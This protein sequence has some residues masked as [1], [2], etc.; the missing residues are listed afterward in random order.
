MALNS[1]DYLF[2]YLAGRSPLHRMNA[3]VKLAL[4]FAAS[5]AACF[6]PLS[7]AAACALPAG[8]CARACGLPFRVQLRDLRPLLFYGEFLY[9]SAVLSK[10]LALPEPFAQASAAAL[11][12]TKATL[13]ALARL[14]LLLQLSSLLFRTTTRL[15]LR[16][17]IAA[18]ETAVRAALARLPGISRAVSRDA[19][20]AQ[21]L[22]LFLGF[23]PA[24]FEQWS[25]LELAWRARGGKNGVVKTRTL[26]L[27]LL[28]LGFYAAAQ[29]AKALAARS[30]K[31]SVR[32][33][34]TS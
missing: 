17:G 8:M 16:E 28:S 23:I 33:C 14:L 9:A 25:R 30:A 31:P 2:C 5:L 29:K 18:A 11:V 22:A 12:P 20:F 26:L 6:L 32:V 21:T 13:A 1:N 7:V 15:A 10:V 4:L 24:L 27:S 34:R 3:A 19:R